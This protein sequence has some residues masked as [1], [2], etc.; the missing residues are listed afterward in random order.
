MWY[1][2][3]V[4]EYKFVSIYCSLVKKNINGPVTKNPIPCKNS[5]CYI[6]QKF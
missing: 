3:Y 4:P 1:Y 6:F 5:D 2:F